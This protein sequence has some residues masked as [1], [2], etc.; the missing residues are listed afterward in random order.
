MKVVIRRTIEVLV[1]LAVIVVAVAVGWIWR[2]YLARPGRDRQ[3]DGTRR[4]GSGA[5]AADDN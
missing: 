4:R 1:G 3:P 5:G 2:A